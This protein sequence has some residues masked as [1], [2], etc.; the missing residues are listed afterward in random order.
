MTEDRADHRP[1]H[2]RQVPPDILLTNYKMLDYLLL[3][4]SDQQLWQHNLGGPLRYLVVDELHTFDGA[5]GFLGGL[6]QNYRVPGLDDL[7]AMNPLEAESPEAYLEAQIALWFDSTP[8]DLAA[9][10]KRHT[11]FHT[12]LGTLNGKAMPWS[13]LVK[14]GAA[15]ELNEARLTS[16][17]ALLSSAR[18]DGRPLLEVRLQLW[19]RELRRMVGAVPR[20][21]DDLP[22]LAFADDLKEEDRKRHL[23]VIH[24]RE[25][26]LTGWGG[27]IKDADTAVN[28]DL[29]AFYSAFFSY[30]HNVAFLFPF[31][32]NERQRQI[33]I[34]QRLC[35][36]C[37]HLQRMTEPQSCS[38]CG[39]SNDRL[40][41]VWAPTMTKTVKGK[42]GSDYI[43]ST[44][45][46]PSCD[47]NNSLTILGSRAAS[48][49]SVAIS[50]LYASPFNPD[51]KMLAF[52]DRVQDAS[53]RSGFF[54]A[55]TYRFNLRAAIQQALEAAGGSVGLPGL[56][57]V[58]LAYW[59][60]RMSPNELIATFLPPDMDWLEDYA[61]LRERG[62]LPENSNLEKLLERRLAWEIWAE[63]TLDSRIGR[64][65]EK[66]SCSTLEVVSE[67]WG[68]AA[69]RLQTQLPEQIGFLREAQPEAMAR[70]LAGVVQYLKNRGGVR[71]AALGAYIADLGR[72]Y[73]VSQGKEI[74]R[75]PTSPKSR[76]PIFLA[77]KS[78][79]TFQTV[80]GR[81]GG[82]P[83][84]FEE[85][86][87][88]C[89]GDL[90]P[91]VSKFARDIYP[92][93]LEELVRAGLFFQDE[94]Q[95]AAVWGLR[96]E[97]LRV[98]PTVH[99]LRCRLC[100]Y[101]LSVGEADSGRLAGAACMRSNCD[102]RLEAVASDGEY[103]RR[104]Y[105]DGDVERIFA[106][107]HTGLLKREVR[108]ETEEG[109]RNRTRPGDPNLL[110]CTPTL[111]MGINIG[112]LSSLAL[113]SVPP[114]AANYLQR[115]GRAGRVDGNSFVLT[116]A[117]GRPHDL[118]FFL[119]PEEMIQGHVEAPGCFLNASAV[120]QRQ[121]TAFVLDR[122]VES[123]IGLN[124][125]PDEMRPVLD[126][127]ESGRRNRGF[128]GTFLTFFQDNRTALEDS[129]LAMFGDEMADYTR[130]RI[131]AFSRGDDPDVV[132]L[133]E[134]IWSGLAEVAEERKSLRGRIQAMTKKIRTMKEEKARALDHEKT[135]ED[136]TLEKEGINSIV[137]EMNK[138]GVLNFLTDEGLLPNYAFPEAGVVLR[139]VIY[140]KKQNAS[141]G[142][143]KYTTYS[144]EY[145]RPAESAIVE[146]APSNKFYA[147]GRRVE[148]DQVNLQMSKPEFWRFCR[149]CSHLEKE[150]TSD[151][152]TS[153][154]RCGDPMWVDDG[155]RRQMLRMR[156][157]ISTTDERRSRSHDEAE[158]PEPRFYQKNMF[159]VKDDA[160]ITE[161]YFLDDDTVPFGFEFF[162]K[163]QLV[164][165]NFGEPMAAA[166]SQITIAGRALVDSPFELCGSCGKVKKK[167]RNGIEHSITCRYRGKEEQEKTL[168]ACFLYREFRSEA[169]RMLLPV[170]TFQVEQNTHS[171]LAALELGL[172]KLFGGDL[173]HLRT[174]MM[175]E[176]IDGS[177]IRK[178][179]LVLYDGVPGGTG[180]LKDLMRDEGQIIRAFQL[181]YDELRKC[182]CEA[183]PDKD[184]CYRCLLAYRGRH[185]QEN[186]SRQRAMRMLEGILENRQKLRR[187][188][189]L[190][191]IRI[192][193]LLESELERRFIEA[194]RRHEDGRAKRIVES[195]VV[196][197]KDGFLLKSEHGNFLI[198]P[199]VQLGRED[200]V[201]IPSIAD[202]VLYPERPKDGELPIAVF[203]D[204]YEYHADPREKIR[205]ATDTA[206][207]V[208]IVRSGKF[209]V[210]SLT[211]DDVVEALEAKSTPPDKLVAFSPGAQFSALLDRMTESEKPFWLRLMSLSSFGILT[212]LLGE[213]RDCSW[214]QHAAAFAAS[215]LEKDS[216]DPERMR[217]SRQITRSDGSPLI[218]ADGS[219]SFA[220]LRDRDFDQLKVQVVLH[221]DQAG[222]GDTRWRQAWREALRLANFLQFMPGFELVSSL[223]IEA[224]QY[225]SIAAGSLGP[226]R[227]SAEAIG[228]ALLQD[229]A[230]E[231][232]DLCVKALRL[233]LPSPEAGFEL[234]DEQGEIVGTA[235]MAWPEAK[236]VVLLPAEESARP[237]F[238]NE[239][240][241][242]FSS[243][244]LA[245][246]PEALFGGLR[247]RRNSA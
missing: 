219:M 44:H 240:W 246:S 243:T 40:L 241:E 133:E 12:L 179:Y 200:G 112:D 59:R 159:V 9:E 141:A 81:G 228:Q 13:A 209:R 68:D 97:A 155:R 166:G 247:R 43:R 238:E 165:V 99:Q 90:E 34:P 51:K 210:W 244:T 54:A 170:A 56:P 19:L 69:E 168:E 140:R 130:E 221:D 205:V 101:S 48:L 57:Q 33:E 50:Q 5:Q 194:L 171:F 207:R 156:Q 164:E 131:R 8:E 234:V 104:L 18:M 122:W 46:C 145:E 151:L 72:W 157:V 63:Y 67:V 6:A 52:S 26:G 216:S 77:S 114:K 35:V 213:G 212:A 169:I 32:E 195:K 120:L 116:L 4:P 235:E 124:A 125:L 226:S 185:D 107:E 184:G 53:H 82:K 96:S 65:L 30:S 163:V 88:K 110:S 83:T 202:F 36:D 74:W 78:S 136:L 38:H 215:L 87:G 153:C 161:A 175:D 220:A 167:G 242:T 129:F 127:V 119:E 128:P 160:D 176:P 229:L 232:H 49:T 60:E 201:A 24:C 37:L 85:W 76:L 231:L 222:D 62:E 230:P 31:T 204:G 186:T 239:G 137:T 177:D 14:E 42:N 211:W 196:G 66:S 152:R 71:N 162:R 113:C 237:L 98:T 11:Y 86:L 199:Q 29:T 61:A 218:S 20:A 183:D 70:F 108:E 189:K 146:L 134:S 143:G 121:F 193:R 16:F 75:P 132:G 47:G 192:N 198:E 187:T 79:D 1:R 17:L 142:E 2:L 149:T 10:I 39:A 197:G 106:K 3:R 95:G 80:V 64:T 89:F 123:G 102:G 245:D 190:E 23:P 138:K 139:S 126:A 182:R 135:L 28:P 225:E 188:K 27:T 7:A 100:S 22:D 73:H 158:D 105:R 93:A 203:T 117:T 150:G 191:G 236:V 103:Y 147:E 109:F 224:D 55:R 208:A 178:Q 233:G 172:R 115:V 84:W 148:V 217:I 21:V 154:P 223:G 25:C 206:Q 58:F 227:E 94:G 181:A 15:R 91:Q 41:P 214:S 173:G 118:F 45:D 92:I 111:E 180:Y 174:A 144:Y